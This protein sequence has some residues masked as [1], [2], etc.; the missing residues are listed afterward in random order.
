MIKNYKLFLY[1][2]GLV[3]I[4]KNCWERDYDIIITLKKIDYIVITLT[5]K[6]FKCVKEIT[7]L[8]L[9]TLILYVIYSK[10]IC[11]VNRMNE[12]RTGTKAYIYLY[13]Y[14]NWY[15]SILGSK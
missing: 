6:L 4:I 5:R 8:S 7:I 11:W 15:Q 2:C 3:K 1:G 10:A 13:V 9:H 12:E 14:I